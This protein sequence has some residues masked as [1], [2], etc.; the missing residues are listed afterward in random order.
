[1]GNSGSNEVQIAIDLCKGCGL[2]IGACPAGVLAQGKELNRQGY[3]VATYNGSGCTGCSI[4]FY[5]CPEPGAITVRFRKA[6]KNKP[7]A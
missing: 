5:V 4:C 2:C 6:D 3:F 1:M 7:A